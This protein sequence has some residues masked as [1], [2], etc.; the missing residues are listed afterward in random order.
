MGNEI[1]KYKLRFGR[2]RV[3]LILEFQ[4][5]KYGPAHFKRDAGNYIRRNKIVNLE[6]A[7]P[8]FDYFIKTVSE[9]LRAVVPQ[10]LNKVPYVIQGNPF[11]I[12]LRVHDADG[13]DYHSNH[14]E[15][16]SRFDHMYIDLNGKSLT[17]IF[18]APF[19]FRRMTYV[20]MPDV[21]LS[22]IVD[23]VSL[24]HYHC[25]LPEYKYLNALKRRVMRRYGIK[26]EEVDKLQYPSLIPFFELLS[27]LKIEGLGDFIRRSGERLVFDL[28]RVDRIRK[29]L[30]R[31]VEGMK[32][33]MTLKRIAQIYEKEYYNLEDSDIEAVGRYMC[34]FIAMALGKH[35]NIKGITS[36]K[37]YYTF[38]NL[39]ELLNANFVIDS[40]PPKICEK[41]IKLIHGIEAEN[42][43]SRFIY[44]YARACHELGIPKEY[45]ILDYREYKELKRKALGN[46]DEEW[47]HWSKRAGFVISKDLP[48][49]KML[50]EHFAFKLL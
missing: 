40:L 33:P 35:M 38:E 50:R 21:R 31:L 12:E 34:F 20:N 39:S 27:D 43:H 36:N 48:F 9:T 1:R 5:E 24:F 25:N 4:T 49:K 3:I 10:V 45:T 13:D 22:L 18:V 47:K 28:S 46:S 11:V 7:Y 42:H 41:A 37:R 19:Y 14:D 16:F 23:L 29:D 26:N 44:L 2:K 8:N 6:D 17:D 32:K 30:Q 15:E